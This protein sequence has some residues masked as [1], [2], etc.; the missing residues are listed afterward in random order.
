MPRQTFL[1][2]ET[3]INANEQHLRQLI[4]NLPDYIPGFVLRGENKLIEQIRFSSTSTKNCPYVIDISVLT[5]NDQYTRLSIHTAYENGKAFVSDPEMNMMM[6]EIEAAIQAAA[7][8]ETYT[9]KT[10]EG[11]SKA[12]SSNWFSN[13]KTGINLLFLKKKIA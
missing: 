13:L 9:R 7:K 11:V 5:L 2:K 10:Q 1:S 12:G 6:H 4:L 8:G 3:F